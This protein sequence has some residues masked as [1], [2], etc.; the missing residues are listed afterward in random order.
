M[1]DTVKLCLAFLKD[2]NHTI[3]I[4]P[5]LRFYSEAVHAEEGEERDKRV[6]ELETAIKAITAF[7]VFW[8]ATR[9]GTGNIDSQYRAV[10][11]GDTLTGMGPLARQWADPRSQRRE[12][13]VDADALRAELA[14]RL[15]DT[16]SK[17]EAFRTLPRLWQQHQPCPFTRSAAAYAIP[18]TSGLS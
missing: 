14:A 1:T 13:E 4:A 5:L 18:S 15:T 2:L 8:R 17:S 7:T 11:A 3:A 10:M 9:R 16:D 12:P 6:A